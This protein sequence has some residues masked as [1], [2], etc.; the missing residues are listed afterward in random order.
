MSSRLTQVTGNSQKL[1]TV[2][3]EDKNNNNDDI[4]TLA[5]PIKNNMYPLRVS[6]LYVHEINSTSFMV[7]DLLKR[8]IS[9]AYRHGLNLKPGRL[10]NADGNCVWESITYNMLYRECFKKK[11]RLSTS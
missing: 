2:T 4:N 6:P 5:N 3:A 9:N 10:N 11:L 1:K 7:N 8:A